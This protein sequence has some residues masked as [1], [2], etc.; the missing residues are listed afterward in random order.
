MERL[1]PPQRAVYVLR[2]AFDLPYDEVAAIVDRAPADCRQLHRRAARAMR[3]ARPRFTP[4]RAEH[5]RLLAD[6]L[7]AARSGDLSRLTRLL[8][9][10]AVV[11]SDGGGRVRAARN[12]IISAAK[13]ARF[14]AGIYS[15]TEL[16]QIPGRTQRRSSARPGQPGG[17]VRA[18]RR[19]TP[20]PD[21]HHLDDQQP[22]QALRTRRRV[23][24]K[25]PPRSLTPRSDARRGPLTDHRGW[26]LQLGAAA[27]HLPPVSIYLTT[28]S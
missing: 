9:P 16:V 6:F 25:Q 27:E 13:A 10:D 17:Q 12:P 19:R 8:H 7:D 4:S 11:H 3:A 5:E 20:R 24:G 14:C 2:T 18:D 22:G 1:T 21:H 15:R 23:R 26:P 28:V